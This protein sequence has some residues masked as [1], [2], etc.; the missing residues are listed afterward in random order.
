MY[1]LA[2]KGENL[3]KICAYISDVGVKFEQIATTKIIV[4]KELIYS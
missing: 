4:W 3:I 1:I 2:S